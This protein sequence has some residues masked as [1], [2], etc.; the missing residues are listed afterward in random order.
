[1]KAPIASPFDTL[2]PP[3]RGLGVFLTSGDCA[4]L[5]ARDG[6][7]AELADM[8]ASGLRWA[9]IWCESFDGRRIDLER[10]E[11]VADRL[12]AAGLEVAT[13][14]F[15]APTPQ[16]AR[17]AA[18]H[19]AAVSRTVRSRLAILDME[20]PDGARGEADW[21]DDEADTLVRTTIDGITERTMLAV[22]S[23]PLRK[24]HGMPW[25]RMVAGVGVPQIYGTA[26]D[27]KR[28][29]EALDLW[30]TAHGVVIPA[31]SLRSPGAQDENVP[32]EQLARRL[33]T[34]AGAGVDAA[35]LWS[36]ALLRRSEAHQ[37][38]VSAW[39]RARGW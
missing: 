35:A 16:S 13:W 21:T 10:A 6:A 26:D 28:A 4:K 5:D 32:P 18:L 31:T 2:A 8:I 36:W 17:V 22:S 38:R 30:R 37:A 39:A 33:D 14:T 27:P 7:A 20:D 12:R 3:V 11:R 1:M 15:P 25:G 24:G 34:V 19:I 9:A 23:Y 29:R